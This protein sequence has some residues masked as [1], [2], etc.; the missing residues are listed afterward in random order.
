MASFNDGT[1]AVVVEIAVRGPTVEDF[2]GTD[3]TDLGG[4][5]VV[6]NVEDSGYLVNLKAVQDQ[7]PPGID[8]ANVAY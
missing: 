6:V 5:L 8:D 3:Q 4:G 2:D 7:C 1:I